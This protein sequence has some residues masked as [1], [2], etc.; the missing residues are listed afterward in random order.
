MPPLAVFIR[1]GICFDFFVNILLTVAGYIP[2]HLHNFFIQRVRDNSRRPDRTPK[3]LKRAGLVDDTRGGSSNRQW[4]DRYINT[5]RPTQYDDEGRAHHLYED[6]DDEAVE[7]SDP[8]ALVEPDRF[9]NDGPSRHRNAI[10][11]KASA[12]S[13]MPQST[14]DTMHS[15]TKN[16]SIKSRTMRFFGLRSG[17]P[18]TQSNAR[19][20]P[21]TRRDMEGRSTFDYDDENWSPT[22]RELQRRTARDAD[23]PEYDDWDRELMGLSTR[24]NYPPVRAGRRAAA[25]APAAPRATEMDDEPTRDILEFE[26]TF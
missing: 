20:D 4:A 14:Y 21:L 3:W 7:M 22:D 6:D 18:R 5:S 19:D 1:F 24:S 13:L 23:D 12:S 8:H 2:G 9:I 16:H 15:S 10:R 11:H 25:N 17:P 26:H